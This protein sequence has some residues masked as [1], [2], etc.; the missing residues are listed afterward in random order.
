MLRSFDPRSGAHTPD[1]EDPYYGTHDDF[2]DVFTV[3]EAALPGSARLG[4]RAT[5][6]PRNRELMKRWSFLLRPQWLALFVV[7]IAF[8]YLCFTVL[9][10]WQLGKNTK[11]SRENGQISPVR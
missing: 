9:A 4:G 8:A 7:V 6:R 3:I 10:P 5:G 1:V 2:E 11:T